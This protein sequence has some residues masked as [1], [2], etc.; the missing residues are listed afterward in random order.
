MAT[1]KVGM[2][3]VIVFQTSMLQNIERYMKQAIVDK[4]PAVSS[5]A[6]VSS[7]VSLHH[8]SPIAWILTFLCLFALLIWL[9]SFAND[10]LSPNESYMIFAKINTILF[11]LGHVTH[12]SQN[13]IKNVMMMQLSILQTVPWFLVC[14]LTAEHIQK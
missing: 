6:L 14:V 12:I 5:A 4:V 11:E 10:V 1:K 13:G 7:L 3:Y 9:C 2:I 8:S